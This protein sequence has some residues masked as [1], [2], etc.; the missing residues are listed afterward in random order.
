MSDAR[1]IGVAD[2]GLDHVPIPHDCVHVIPGELGA[3]AAA[4][5]YAQ[6]LGS[7]GDFDLVLL[8]LGEDGH[9][10]SLFPGRDRSATPG[11]ADVF[12]VL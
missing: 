10:A 6:M 12:A 1:W 2:A 11:D 9:T 5:A 8:G 4:L 3:R 7:T